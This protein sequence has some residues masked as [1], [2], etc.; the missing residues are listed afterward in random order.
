VG[1]HPK[2]QLSQIDPFEY[3]T[4][5]FASLRV[6]CPVI[7]LFA[8]S[9]CTSTAESG[10]GGVMVS[11]PAIYVAGGEKALLYSAMNRYKPSAGVVKVYVATPD[12]L[13]VRVTGPF[14]PF[15]M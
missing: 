1:S 13:V 7:G 2:I 10:C 15:V 8:S 9:V 11:N 12:E 6:I 5:P 3:T 4:F 14:V